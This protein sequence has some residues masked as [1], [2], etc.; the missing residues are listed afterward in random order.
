MVIEPNDLELFEWLCNH[1][2]EEPVNPRAFASE[3]CPDTRLK[4]KLP[5]LISTTCV[6]GSVSFRE[7]IRI[8]MKNEQKTNEALKRS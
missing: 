3:I 7:A 5:V 1:V 8:A 2:S 4:F 6:N